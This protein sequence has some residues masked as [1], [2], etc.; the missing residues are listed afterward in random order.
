MGHDARRLV[1]NS[2]P[3]ATCTAMARRLLGDRT[4]ART[5]CEHDGMDEG[6]TGTWT[7]TVVHGADA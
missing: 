3:L 7:D 5:Y 2:M 4:W 6:G 1:R